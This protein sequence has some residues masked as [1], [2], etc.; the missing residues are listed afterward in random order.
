MNLTFLGCGDAF[1]TGGRFNTCFHVSTAEG[2]F[3]IDCGASSLIAMRKFGV[4]PNDIRTIFISHLHGDHF[5]GLPFFLGE[6]RFYSRRTG[7]L[8]IAG[9][10]GLRERLNTTMEA[11]YPGSTQR[12]FKFAIDVRE[13]E[14]GRTH[15][16]NGV[17]VT[18]FKVAHSAGAPPYALRLECEGKIIA[19][20]GDTEWTDALIDAGRGADLFI[21]ECL[22]AE[23]RVKFHMDYPTLSQN[24]PRVGARCV[25]LTHLGPEMLARLGDIPEETAEDGKVIEL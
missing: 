8:T 17:R 15:E 12:E 5:G 13:I 20:S 3:L 9:P 22:M 21:V 2:A 14:T 19:Y 1:G 24:L 11:L 7:P 16:I 23:R 10:A 18:P 4:E 25:I 6:A